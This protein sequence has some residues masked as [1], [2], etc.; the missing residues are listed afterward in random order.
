MLRTGCMRSRRSVVNLCL[1]TLQTYL[2]NSSAGLLSIKYEPGRAG[3]IS[4]GSEVRRV[5][6][7]FFWIFWVM[8]KKLWVSSLETYSWEKV[9]MP[10]RGEVVDT[11]NSQ[12]VQLG[13]ERQD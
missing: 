9:I 13:W 1:L 4:D 7:T 10:G 2:I 3:N 12:G 8:V 5:P 11:V 6:L